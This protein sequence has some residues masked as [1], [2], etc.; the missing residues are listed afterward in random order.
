MLT[1]A[2]EAILFASAKPTP[3][4][5]LKKALDVSDEVLR[6]A[7]DDIRARLNTESS[8]IHLVEADGKLQLV[9]NPAE[10]EQLGAFFKQEV[11]GELTRPSLETLTIIAYRGPI[12]KPE[13]EQIRGVNC[14]LILRNLL[15]RALVEEREDVERLQ[16]VYTVS[17]KFLRHLGL[18]RAQELPEFEAYHGNEKI[19]EL[20]ALGRSEDQP[21]GEASLSRGAPSAEEGKI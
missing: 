10:A 13:I 11:S 6:E 16:P 1:T 15:M 8:G 2:I 20:L 9:T 19:G 17:A 4:S 7:I 18:H 14:S 21:T 5:T 3:T 12:T